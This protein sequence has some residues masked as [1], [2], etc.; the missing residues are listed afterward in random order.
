MK[1]VL[2]T[3]G[4][5]CFVDD[6]A[7]DIV[8]CYNWQA[9]VCKTSVMASKTFFREGIRKKIFLHK[10]LAGVPACF[11]V[12]HLN[13][14]SLDNQYD[15]LF[16]Y[17]LKGNKYNFR[18]FSIKSKF[19]GV[20][21]NGYHG[22]WDARF[23]KMTIGFYT[24]EIDAARAYNIKIGDIYKNER[25]QNKISIMRQYNLNQRCPV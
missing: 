19:K 14:N 25:L 10:L 22:L 20:F 12:G 15:N 5:K 17:D 18:K 23:H 4:Y 3:R 24:N 1:E 8:N 2:L 6:D 7:F 21:W 11:K 13:G 9:H 16:I